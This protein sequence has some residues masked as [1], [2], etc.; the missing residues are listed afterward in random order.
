MKPLLLFLVLAGCARGTSVDPGKPP[1]SGSGGSVAM[2][3][4]PSAGGA[5]GGAPVVAALASDAAGA[6]CSGDVDCRLF[7]DYCTGCGCRALHRSEPDPTCTGPGVRCLRQP[8]A[9]RV[10]ACESGHCV[11]REVPRK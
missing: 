4:M 9:D 8:C 10:A 2:A 7:D 11:V 3:T 6:A 5:G 1:P